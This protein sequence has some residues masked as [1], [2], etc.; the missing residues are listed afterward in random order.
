MTGTIPFT[1]SYVGMPWGQVHVATSGTGPPLLLLHSAPR[2]GVEFHEVLGQIPDR[3]CLAPDLPGLGASDRWPEKP[4]VQSY[5]SAMW[6]VCDRLGVANLSIVGHHGGGV[7]ALEMAAAQPDRVDSLVLSS[8]P[9]IGPAERE[10]RAKNGIFYGFEAKDD[11]SHIAAMAERR[12]PWMPPN[13]PKLWNRLI[14]DV[15]RASDDPETPLRAIGAYQ[16]EQRIGLL[17]CPTLLLARKSDIW[18][19]QRREFE[20]RLAISET[21]VIEGTILIE[22]E[23]DRLVAAVRGFL[24]R[25]SPR[26]T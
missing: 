19:E 24:E 3:R 21:E 5:A 8:T 14:V 10:E 9:W 15:L 26:R 23:P 16:M 6:A 2:S 13:Q 18:F 17:A 4:T 22:D 20:T 7:V 1:R 12:R 25:L 11:L